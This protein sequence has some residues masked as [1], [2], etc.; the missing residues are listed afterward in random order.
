MILWAIKSTILLG[1][2]FA[3]AT[4]MRRASPA[5][6]HLLWASAFLAVAGLPLLDGRVQGP[7]IVVASPVAR[8]VR[9]AP[10][11]PVMDETVGEA[12]TVSV[13]STKLSHPFEWE[14]ALRAAYLI[15]LTLTLASL[16]ASLARTRRALRGSE[17]L[18]AYGTE[19]W[20]S[21]TLP[22]PVTFGWR[23][24]VIMLPSAAKTWSEER[25]RVV[26]AHESAHILRGDW[27]WQTLA[28]AVTAAQWFNPIAWL[29][30]RR[31]R[32][33]A[34]GAADDAVLRTGISASVYASELLDLV[35]DR[36]AAE[37]FAVPMARGEGVASR[38]RD[39][40]AADRNRNVPTR[41][42]ARISLIGVCVCLLMTG[43]V[44]VQEIAVN[45]L[46]P[47]PIASSS[48][49]DS[50]SFPHSSPSGWF[51]LED[52]SPL[53]VIAVQRRDGRGLK[54]W[55]SAG[56]ELP[57]RFTEIFPTPGTK[58]MKVRELVIQI[59]PKR[60][61]D[62]TLPQNCELLSTDVNSKLGFMLVA[63]DFPPSALTTSVRLSFREGGVRATYEI[64]DILLEP[65]PPVKVDPKAY[66]PSHRLAD[67]S[68][69]RVLSVEER[70]DGRF[71]RAWGPD[72]GPVS[73]LPKSG[74]GILS[75]G[76]SKRGRERRE[77]TVEVANGPGAKA[78]P[79][80]FALWTVSDPF[81]V[82][83]GS[84]LAQTSDGRIGLLQRQVL[85]FPSGTKAFDLSLRIPT[86][87][88][89]S[90]VEEPLGGPILNA[91]IDP[92]RDHGTI[93][94]KPLFWIRY[95]PP[96]ALKYDQLRLEAI[97]QHG[98]TLPFAETVEGPST[99]NG[100]VN[101]SMAYG[102]A[103]RAGQKI[104]K[105]RL[106]DRKTEPVTFPNIALQPKG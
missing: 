37:A 85:S 45:N 73:K 28:L 35:R 67:G 13:T 64:S 49:G 8:I 14:T 1:L 66:I 7:Q 50:Q 53:H 71:A 36:R 34:E 59:P 84:A 79:T 46:S 98:K 4:L 70:E 2:V 58:G 102:F 63:A 30:L 9:S 11:A 89:T 33:E 20:L 105:V 52:G 62:V 81:E 48:F 22:V 5:A 55:N 88:W 21:P 96:T 90:F 68:V 93:N 78:H 104:V 95:I 56:E 19:V 47:I 25:V 91:K 77:I 41:R 6:R 26:I 69:V 31:L 106:S 83:G 39:I 101:P 94:G 61:V 32:A 97:D 74:D 44:G 29:A 60:Q 3:L 24:P 92:A 12:T 18:T 10:S 57:P 72:G 80:D 38:V 103:T 23:R 65:A 54:A 43:C 40:L 87:P 27:A 100:T 51:Q 17:P 15:G 86:G 42:M 76:D 99:E 16:G 82:N 75:S